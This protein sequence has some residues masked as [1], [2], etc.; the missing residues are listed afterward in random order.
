[1][2]EFD[3]QGAETPYPNLTKLGIVNYVRDPTPHA[4]FGGS[5]ATWVVWANVTCHILLLFLS[6]FAIFSTRPTSHFL[7][8]QDDLYLVSSARGY[9]SN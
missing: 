7:T 8:N 2:A 6:V 9:F 5:S 1:M 4:N 3:P